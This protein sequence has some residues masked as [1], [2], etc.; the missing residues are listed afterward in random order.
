MYS[1]DRVLPLTH[2]AESSATIRRRVEEAR[3]PQAQRFC[4][5]PNRTLNSDVVAPREIVEKFELAADVESELRS[6]PKTIPARAP[7]RTKVVTLAVARTIADLDGS[8]ELGVEHLGEAVEFTQ[9]L[10]ADRE[11]RRGA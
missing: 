7:M 6:A 3:R 5:E 2:R 11:L 4:A 8:D 1:P 9:E 10:S